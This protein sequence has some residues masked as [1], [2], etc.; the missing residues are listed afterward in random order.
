MRIYRPAEELRGYV[1]Y[2][3]VEERAEPAKVLTFPIGCPQII[4]HRKSQLYIPD[5]GEFQD[6]FVISGQVNF[7][8]HIQ[9]E[10]AL[11]T[12]V[13]VFYP[14]TLGMFIDTPPSAIYN[15]EISGDDLD[16]RDLNELA[17]RVFQCERTEDCIVL[18]ENWLLSRIRPTL[19]MAR[20][21]DAVKCL[22]VSPSVRVNTLADRACLGKKQFE[23][24][25]REQVGMNPKEYARVVRF[26]KSL[27]LLQLGYEDYV[28]IAYKVGYSDQSHFIREFKAM[29]GY[30]PASLR[31]Y[32][33]PYSDLFTNPV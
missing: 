14:H 13:A 6:R 7:P 4:F 18:I 28:G 10:G 15:L 17:S 26:Q 8:A 24:V 29:S 21:K 20:I 25:F 33:V 3:W 2:Y 16:K 23:R 27:W 32:C 19:N 31:N 30:T 22:M 11:E 5:V 9:S 1:R 12:I